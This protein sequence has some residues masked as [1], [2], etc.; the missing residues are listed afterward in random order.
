MKLKCPKCDKSYKLTTTKDGITR[1]SY[2][3]YAGLA[4]EFFVE[5]KK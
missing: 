4:K 2:C 1:C 3:G 5:E